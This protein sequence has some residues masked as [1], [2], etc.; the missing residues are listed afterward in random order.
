MPSAVPQ[1]N[2]VPIETTE[3]ELLGFSKAYT[4]VLP[5]SLRVCFLMASVIERS[6]SGA[7]AMKNSISY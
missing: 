4:D 2:V 6:N 1:R 7:F 3:I 5:I